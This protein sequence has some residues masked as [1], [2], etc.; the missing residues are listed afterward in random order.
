MSIF[1][2]QMPLVVIESPYAGDTEANEE[3]ARK[4]MRDCLIRGEAPY[5]SHLLYTQPS[6]LDDTV[7]EERNLGISAGFAF[8][9]KADKT[10]VYYD[11][12]ISTGMKHGI[13]N[14]REHGIP[15]EFRSLEGKRR[16]YLAGPME[17]AEDN[18]LGWR[19]EYKQIL[20]NLNIQCIIP[21]EEEANILNGVDLQALKKSNVESHN[22]IL[23]QF[24]RQDLEF[25]RT[26]DM[27][28][29]RWEGEK[30]SGTIGEAQH[31]YLNNKPVYLVTSQPQHTV[32]GWFLACCTKVF[33]NSQQLIDFLRR[34]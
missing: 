1:N 33:K 23:R 19:L 12:G 9:R 15:I 2:D 22:K 26:V 14:A 17:Y 7:P 11:H 13:R 10:V 3:Y 31:A 21:N 16:A 32:P 34:K 27:I 24:I 30:M 20:S 6:V 4:A 25:V 18:G 28:I 29:I 8:R 5:A